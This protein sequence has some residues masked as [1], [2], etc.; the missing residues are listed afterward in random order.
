MKKY[1]FAQLK[2]GEPGDY[3]EVP[4]IIY[5]YIY[6]KGY[7]DGKEEGELAARKDI[8]EARLELAAL[9]LKK[10]RGEPVKD[11]EK[12]PDQLSQKEISAFIDGMRARRNAS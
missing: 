9:R 6:Q 12:V 4:A 7:R 10:L 3:W 8:A 1:A 11:D 2:R 5:D